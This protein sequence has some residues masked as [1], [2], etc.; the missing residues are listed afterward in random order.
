[1]KYGLTGCAISRD[2]RVYGDGLY[3]IQIS[4]LIWQH[5]NEKANNNYDCKNAMSQSCKDNQKQRKE[6]QRQQQMTI[7]G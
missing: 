1:M 7:N 4:S 3:I 2:R 6:A 5:L